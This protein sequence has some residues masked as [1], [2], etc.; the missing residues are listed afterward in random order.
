MR[1]RTVWIKQTVMD[2]WR[3]SAEVIGPKSDSKDLKVI[4][5]MIDMELDFRVF[6]TETADVYY[7]RIDNEESFE[8]NF[9][10]KGIDFIFGHPYQSRQEAVEA[11]EVL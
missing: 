9:H 8:E 2:S 11:G 4:A 6:D 3:M 1:E 7:L 5:D 10:D